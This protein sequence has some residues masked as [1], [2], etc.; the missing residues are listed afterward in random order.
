M[1][2][3]RVYLAARLHDGAIVF[4]A[5]SLVILGLFLS[6]CVLSFIFLFFSFIENE[7]S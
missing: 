6:E 4:S 7:I 3:M 5:Q 1:C 2:G